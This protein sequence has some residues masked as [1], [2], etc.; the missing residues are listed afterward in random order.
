M[1]VPSHV[2]REYRNFIHPE[3]IIRLGE[4]TD[5]NS[6]KVAQALVNMIIEDVSE[7]R[8]E[9]YGYTAEQL[10]TKVENDYSA[11]YIL[12]HLLKNVKEL[13]KKR[14]LLKALP[15]RYFY[16]KK[17]KDTESELNALE[18][19][20]RLTFNSASKETKQAVMKEFVRVLK[21]DSSEI[22]SVY[23]VAFFRGGDLAYFLPEDRLLFK[24]HFLSTM[25]DGL[26]DNLLK[27]LEGIGSFLVP[28]DITFFVDSLIKG[29]VYDLEIITEN[30]KKKF[31]IEFDKMNEETQNRVASRIDAWIKVLEKGDVTYG[32]NLTKD[33]K[34]EVSNKIAVRD[35]DELSLLSEEFP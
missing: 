24:H 23:E 9:N 25:N 10:V 20:F 2:I 32:I 22:V 8:R 7:R 19:C 28:E 35:F 16:L 18:T 12:E 31:L 6:A 34:E 30:A 26:N 14:L 4:T 17:Q 15:T 13:E 1:A 27:S 5:E 29:M 33:L 21:E 11:I 3:K